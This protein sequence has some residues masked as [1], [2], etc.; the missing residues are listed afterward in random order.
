MSSS[1]DIDQIRRFHRIVTRRAGALESSYLARGRPLGAARVLFEIGPDGA[2]SR[3][4]RARLGLDSGYLS[5]LL[6]SLKREGLVVL[7]PSP[8]DARQRRIA[9]TDKGLSEIA[10]YD[11]LSDD[12]ARAILAPLG[13]GDRARLVA[14][15]AEVERGLRAGEVVIAFEP[16]DGAEAHAC[17]AAYF[18]EL[19]ER[20][21]EGFDPGAAGQNLG[22]E[23]APPRG[24]FALARLEGEAVGCGGFVALDDETAEIKR[25]WTSPAARGLGVARRLLA[26]LEEEARARGFRRLRLDTNRALREAQAM[27]RK[28]GYREIERYNDNPYA[29]HWFEKAI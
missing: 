24:A 28:A 15:M 14:A 4:L 11:A 18:A 25:V 1:A 27:Y 3:A 7:A 21:V 5:R 10:A 29:H 6:E 20:F 23:F 8:N 26:A 17:L 9:L 22:A 16:A 12:L 2:D 19:A 13:E